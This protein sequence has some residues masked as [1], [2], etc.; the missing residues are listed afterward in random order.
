MKRSIIPIV[1]VGGYG[2][3]ASGNMR[4]LAW[5]ALRARLEQ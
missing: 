4:G 3:T 2:M 1:M 5:T